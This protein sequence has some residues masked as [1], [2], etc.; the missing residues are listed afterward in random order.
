LKNHNLKTWP[1]FYQEVKSG[2]KT[3]EERLDDRGYEVGDTLTL[4]EFDP[5]K[6]EYTGDEIVKGV[7]YLLREPYAKDGH[8]IMSITEPCQLEIP[9]PWIWDNEVVGL[10][11]KPYKAPTCPTCNEVTYSMPN[12]PFCG[13]ALKGLGSNWKDV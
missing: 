12:C 11:D 8:V 9:K 6:Q 5:D 7:P 3:F 4:Q 13:Q 1:I 2:K 10:D